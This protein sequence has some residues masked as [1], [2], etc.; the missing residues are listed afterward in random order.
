[1]NKIDKIEYILSF[2]PAIRQIEVNLVIKGVIEKGQTF[3]LPIWTPGSYCVRDYAK[4]ITSITAIE[5]ITQKNIVLPK[6]D[7]HTY[8]CNDRVENLTI[9]YKLYANDDSI[10]GAYCDNDRVFINGSAVFLKIIGF[11]S[12]AITVSL[13]QNAYYQDFQ[14]AT[15]LASHADSKWAWGIFSA[16]NYDELIDCPIAIAKMQMRSFEVYGVEHTIAFIGEA[17]GNI[18]KVT[19]DVERIC[20]A[21][22]DIFSDKL[23]FDSYLFILHLV[24]NNYGGLEHRNSSALIAPRKCLPIDEADRSKYYLSLLGLFSHEYFHAWHVKRIKPEEFMDMDLGQPI[25]TRLLWVFEGF[26]SYFDDL[27]LVRSGVITKNEYFNLLV[28]MLARF[29]R[30]PGK[31]YQSLADSSFDA[32]TKFYFPNENSVNQCVSYYVKGAIVACLLDMKIRLASNNQHS[33]ITIMRALWKNYGKVQKGVT[34]SNIENLLTEYGVEASFLKQAVYQCTE[35]PIESIFTQF[36]LSIKHLAYYQLGEYYP[37]AKEPYGKQGMFGW[38]VIPTS[39]SLN[40]SFVLEKSAAALAG[41]WSKDEIIAING[42]K[43]TEQNYE[44]LIKHCVV[45]DLVNV[46]FF[47]DGI[48]KTTKVILKEPATEIAY[49]DINEKITPLQKQMINDWLQIVS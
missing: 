2:H 11:E 16:P 9:N 28:N 34:E 32:W 36:G 43:I 48:L 13:V 8:I 3:S 21:Q 14:V 25:H 6:I 18:D 12:L 37:D 33:L 47:R 22:A 31:G 45:G 27:A 44:R 40:V 42:M 49:I 38:Q 26:T 29:N 23:P 35:L 24:E 39:Q 7:N 15:Q 5:G 41:I 4:H 30:M 17:L 20:Q 10:R 46:A 1:M 19:S